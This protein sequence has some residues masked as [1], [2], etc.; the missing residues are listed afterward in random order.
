MVVHKGYREGARKSYCE[1]GSEFCLIRWKVMELDGG[2]GCMT[3]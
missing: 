3:S 2:E 1:M